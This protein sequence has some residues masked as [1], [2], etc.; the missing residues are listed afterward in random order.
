MS[1]ETEK[2]YQ[3]LEE[4]ISI[5]QELKGNKMDSITLKIPNY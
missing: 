4:I 5:C 3:E 1:D 2:V